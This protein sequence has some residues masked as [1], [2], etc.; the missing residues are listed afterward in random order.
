MGR[1]CK[2]D[3]GIGI[4]S[5]DE[6]M[7]CLGKFLR[8]APSGSDVY[9]LF[10][11]GGGNICKALLLGPGFSGLPK[12][13]EFIESSCV[14]IHNEIRNEISPQLQFV[15]GVGAGGVER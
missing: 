7:S 6:R 15:A 3:L 8:C 9:R 5:D 4:G 1:S 11:G 12:L 14:E 13:M 10:F 2:F